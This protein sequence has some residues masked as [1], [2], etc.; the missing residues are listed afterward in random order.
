MRAL[1]LAIAVS[2]SLPAVAK[3]KIRVEEPAF[4]AKS[5]IV[6]NEDGTVIKEH[7]GNAVMP[8]ASISKL[9]LAMVVADQDMYEAITIPNKRTVQSSIPRQV[10]TLSRKELLMLALVKSDNFAAQIL[11]ANHPDCIDEMNRRARMFGMLDTHFVEPTGLSEQNVSTANDLLRLLLIAGQHPV[12]TELSRM[13]SA[14]IYAGKSEI[15]VKNTNPLTQ[16]FDIALSKTG[17]TNPAGGCLV[18]IL[19]SAAGKKLLILLGSK[20]AK[21]RIPDMERL[22]KEL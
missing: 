10:T 6:A 9:M 22:V 12:V 1:I 16:R 20:N 5:Y 15:T 4:S 18:M 21:T 11:C 14:T 7:S 13:P 19:N 8:I 3:P 17:F 2:L